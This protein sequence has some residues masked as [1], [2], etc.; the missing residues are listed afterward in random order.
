[1]EPMS[2]EEENPRATPRSNDNSGS[3]SGNSSAERGPRRPR[4]PRSEG[5]HRNPS[6][7]EGGNG[8]YKPSDSAARREGG[9]ER[10]ER[11]SSSRGGGRFQGGGGRS[12]QSDRR[13]SRP[14]RA[15]RDRHEEKP[16]SKK[17]L[18]ASPTAEAA[19]DDSQG[20]LEELGD[21]LLASVSRSFSLTIKVLPAGVR[22]T[23]QRGLSAG[24]CARH[25]GGH[26]RGA[27][28]QTP[29]AFA[30]LCWR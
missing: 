13:G 8:D 17:E 30:A 3:G 4:R 16:P 1:M 10:S 6:S 24:A 25:R 20:F 12:G 22:R 11:P 29:G 27:R 23:D 28:R 9:N 15:G 14:D 26:R 21:S 5:Q 18:V 2:I 19:K 7:S